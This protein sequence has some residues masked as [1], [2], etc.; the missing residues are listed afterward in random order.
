MQNNPNQ[1]IHTDY[2]A[3]DVFKP[4]AANQL[5]KSIHY[6]FVIT[7]D[8]IDNY[9]ANLSA[10]DFSIDVGGV[11]ASNPDGTSGP[12]ETPVVIPY[13]KPINIFIAGKVPDGYYLNF[14]SRLIGIG[15]PVGNILD[16]TAYSVDGNWDRT[17]THDMVNV[18]SAYPY[19]VSVLV[20]GFNFWST[21]ETP[22]TINSPHPNNKGITKVGS[23]KTLSSGDYNLGEYEDCQIICGACLGGGAYSVS[24]SVG[25]IQSGYRPAVVVADWMQGCTAGSL[26]YSINHNDTSKPGLFQQVGLSYWYNTEPTLYE[27]HPNGAYLY[28]LTKNTSDELTFA[29]PESGK[30]IHIHPNGDIIR[31]SVGSGGSSSSSP[32]IVRDVYIPYK[33]GA[34][35]VGDTMINFDV[36]SSQYA[37]NAKLTVCHDGKFEQI[38][39]NGTTSWEYEC[40]GSSYKHF[41]FDSNNRLIWKTW[42]MYHYETSA[43]SGGQ[44]VPVI[45]NE[46]NDKNCLYISVDKLANGVVYEIVME[47]CA[48]GSNA[49]FCV[50]PGDM[51]FYVYFYVSL[52]NDGTV[53]YPK[54]WAESNTTIGVPYVRP[55]FELLVEATDTSVS[56]PA[57]MYSGVS[58]PSQGKGEPVLARAVIHFA[59]INGEIYVMSY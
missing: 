15:T 44:S 43:S 35:E 23:Y 2:V 24:P 30:L 9:V 47:I 49:R 53:V 26:Y 7:Q 25:H 11:I 27:M 58:S 21:P 1:N 36:T 42:Y 34:A 59:K 13:G 57:P 51:N 20:A 40:V 45:I 52:D 5:A 18:F 31:Q 17:L 8:M 14:H 10:S 33:T 41:E 3:F 48:L 37:D 55:N 50:I 16:C 38:P 46:V 4:M 19:A 56:P 12:W 54:R 32:I 22:V 29:N 28:R 6:D 39:K